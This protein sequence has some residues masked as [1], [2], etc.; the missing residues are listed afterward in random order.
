MEN[1][2]SKMSLDLALMEL[3]TAIHIAECNSHVNMSG[4]YE[5]GSHE[6]FVSRG[7]YD[8]CSGLAVS[9]IGNINDS[10]YCEERII[11]TFEL[12][13]KTRETLRPNI[14][15]LVNTGRMGEILFDEV[16]LRDPGFDVKTQLL[17]IDKDFRKLLSLIEEHNKDYR[18]ENEVDNFDLLWGTG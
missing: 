9:A 3:E 16:T 12:I 11:K 6:W 18:R 4:K 13:G 15:Y 17:G 8:S 10:G 2:D 5:E 14:S 7:L 1:K